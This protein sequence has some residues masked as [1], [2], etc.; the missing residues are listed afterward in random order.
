MMNFAVR[1]VVFL[2]FIVFMGMANAYLV[3]SE[4]IHIIMYVALFMLAIW[5]FIGY[6]SSN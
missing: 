5:V 3:V 2:A 1:L 4:S 6:E